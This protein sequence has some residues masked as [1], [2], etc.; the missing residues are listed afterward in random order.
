MYFY[1]NEEEKLSGNRC[2]DQGNKKVKQKRYESNIPFGL[3]ICHAFN[4]GITVMVCIACF[5]SFA[6]K[7][8]A[9]I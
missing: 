3:L 4:T 2:T 9:V 8:D 1:M 6:V 5:S 7:K